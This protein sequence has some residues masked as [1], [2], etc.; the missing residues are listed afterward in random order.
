MCAAT[1]SA[2]GILEILLPQHTP[3]PFTKVSQRCLFS[4]IARKSLIFVAIYNAESRQSVSNG[5]F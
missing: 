2:Y 5:I 4:V 1:P 3:Q